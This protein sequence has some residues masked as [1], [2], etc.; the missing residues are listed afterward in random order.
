MTDNSETY[1]IATQIEPVYVRDL[2]SGRWQPR[3][4]FDSAALYELAA[5]IRDHGQI[6]PILYWIPAGVGPSGEIVAGERRWR[7]ICAIALAAEYDGHTLEDWAAKCAHINPAETT[8][9]DIEDWAGETTILARRVYADDPNDLYE[10]ALVDNIERANLSPIEE[11]T[12]LRN[13]QSARDLSIRDLAERVGRSHSWVNDRLALLKLASDVIAALSAR[14]D[15]L[16]VA[17][18]RHVGRLDAEYQLGF[19]EYLVAAGATRREAEDVASVVIRLGMLP[20]ITPDSIQYREPFGDND[21]RKPKSLI[22]TLESQWERSTRNLE[23]DYKGYHARRFPLD[24]NPRV[25]AELMTED[26]RKLLP[27]PAACEFCAFSHTSAGERRCLYIACFDRKNILWDMQERRDTEDRPAP[28]M[29]PI[30]DDGYDVEAD[31]RAE[32]ESEPR[33]VPE[34]RPASEPAR[35]LPEMRPIEAPVAKATVINI[36][37]DPGEDLD[38]R[39]VLLT[40]GQ[41]GTIGRMHKGTFADLG[42]LVTRACREHFTPELASAPVT[43]TTL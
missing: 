25:V 18:A 23:T 12:A 29:E 36:I 1:T 37:I 14:T 15:G 20:S 16:S 26:D 34:M 24:W 42:H 11:A 43:N 10:L 28:D 27:D 8:F 22:T 40:I 38:T 5:S 39:P 30:E 13:L 4:S 31:E 17:Q 32:R 21:W 2:A 19:A 9:A 3:V 35:P 41:E 7:A 33:P 6:D